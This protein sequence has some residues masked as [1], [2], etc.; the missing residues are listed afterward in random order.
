MTVFSIYWCFSEEAFLW[1][2]MLVTIYAKIKLHQ[3]FIPTNY[4]NF[5]SGFFLTYLGHTKI[6]KLHTGLI[7]VI[8]RIE[9]ILRHLHWIKFKQMDI[10]SKIK[11]IFAENY[12]M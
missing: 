4:E 8:E 2:T 1:K 5:N 6:W 10:I 11:N 3:R 9:A 12:S 7:W